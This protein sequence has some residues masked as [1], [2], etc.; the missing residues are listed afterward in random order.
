MVELTVIIALLVWSFE[1]D[2]VPENLG[3]FE[4]IDMVT[5]RPQQTYVKLERA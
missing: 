3:G 5:R 2:D 4:A 1:Y